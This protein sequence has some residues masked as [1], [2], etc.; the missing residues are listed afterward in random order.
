MEFD[1]DDHGIAKGGTVTLYIDGKKDGEA[2]IPKIIP[3]RYSLDET[4][5]VGCD[6][7]TVVTPDYEPGAKFTGRI[8]HVKVDLSGQAQHEPEVATRHAMMRQ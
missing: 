7:G 2:E 5:D 8:V 4:F 6:T 3:F 1:Y